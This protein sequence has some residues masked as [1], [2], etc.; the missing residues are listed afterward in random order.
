M[1]FFLVGENNEDFNEQEKGMDYD[2]TIMP[3]FHP[4]ILLYIVENF[5]LPFNLSDFSSLHKSP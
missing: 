3:G 2:E 5:F 4:F 1:F